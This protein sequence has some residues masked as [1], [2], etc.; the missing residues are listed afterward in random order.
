MHLT[1]TLKWFLL[2]T[3]LLAGAAAF[4]PIEA[5]VDVVAEDPEEYD[6]FDE[7]ALPAVSDPFERV[8]RSIFKFNGG[9]NLYVFKPISRGY[10]AVVPGK[11][12]EGLGNFFSN[13]A[14]P[15][16]FVGCVLQGKF[17]RSAA[18]TGKF[19]INSTV[20]VGGFMKPSDHIPELRVPEE[21]I[22]QA[23]GVWGLGHGP[24]LVIPFLGPMS[25]RDGIGRIAEYPLHPMEWEFA[26]SIDWTVRDGS[27]VL[28]TVNSLPG[29]LE[30]LD[31]I[32]RSA[33]DP[34]VAVR[35]GYI[36]YRD[37]AVKR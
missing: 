2:I 9:V 4:A 17:G 26:E 22:G 21:D 28:E 27:R 19:L 8:N 15:A 13:L 25:L 23:F 24:Y 33:V 31:R 30:N 34:Y 35:N 11:A 3:L 10:T 7:Y 1:K 14:F 37:G 36:Q 12:R 16:R 32:T 6:E 20:G 18:E 5:A 29:K